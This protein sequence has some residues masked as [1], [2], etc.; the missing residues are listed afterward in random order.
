MKIAYFDAGSGI[1]G[2]MTVGALLDA[3]GSRL[4]VERLRAALG[5]LDLHGYRIDLA[6]VRV[7]GVPAASFRVTIDET[8]EG[9]RDWQAIR[10]MIESAAARGLT[11]GTVDRSLRVFHALAV[12]EG[13]VHG[14]AADSV[15]FH[16]VG[17]VDSIVDIVSACWCLDEL[18]IEACFV[19]PIPSGSGRVETAH[20][21]LPVPAPATLTLLQGFEV[22]AGDGEGELVTPTGAAI[23]AALAKPLRPGFRLEASGSGAGTRRLADRANVLRVLLGEC[24]GRADDQVAVLESDID[25]M[26]PAALAYVAERLREADARDVTITPIVMKKGRAGLRLTVLCDLEDI[27]RLSEVILAESSSIGVRYRTCARVVLARRIDVVE[28]EFGNVAV[29]VVRR[30]GS[31]EESAEPE[32][33]DLVRAAVAFDK[34]LASV[35]EAVLAAWKR[36]KPDVS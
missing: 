31:E 21:I 19:G 2:D 7:A 6:R 13:R 4:D 3:G 27:R 14:V 8:L 9:E 28:T 34:P 25:D 15:H 12:A 5:L 32:L 20:G 36:S 24:D 23:L 10:G 18:D 17:A 35:R 16:E 11:P 30:P 26:A 29:K 22:V 33:D 1:S